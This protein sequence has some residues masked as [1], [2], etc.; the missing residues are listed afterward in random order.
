MS[1]FPSPKNRP[2]AT[3]LRVVVEVLFGKYLSAMRRLTAT[4]D[5][6]MNAC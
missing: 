6:K 4:A 5:E 2:T 3:K 1:V